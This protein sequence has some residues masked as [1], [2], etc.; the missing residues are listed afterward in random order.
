MPRARTD[1]RMLAMSGLPLTRAADAT[2]ADLRLAFLAGPD[3]AGGIGGLRRFARQLGA[4]G[5]PVVYTPGV[6]HLDTVPAY[7]KLNRVDMGTADKVAVAALAV[8]QQHQRTGRPFDRELRQIVIYCRRLE[9]SFG[10]EREASGD[11]L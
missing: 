1:G 2:E 8:E 7:R 6:I 4:S 5:L 9:P 3:E 10:I 11:G